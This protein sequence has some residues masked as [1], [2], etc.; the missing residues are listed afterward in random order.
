M[1]GMIKNADT[2]VG[3]IFYERSGRG[4]GRTT[5]KSGRAN[6]RVYKIAGRE[7]LIC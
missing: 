4:N 7:A 5:E 1:T 2:F 6:A 3:R